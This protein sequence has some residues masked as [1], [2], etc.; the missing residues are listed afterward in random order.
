MLRSS[1]T[2]V[3]SLL[4]T[5]HTPII[6]DIQVKHLYTS[7][8]QH[9]CLSAHLWLDPGPENCGV[10]IVPLRLT[11]FFKRVCPPPKPGHTLCFVWVPTFGCTQDLKIAHRR[12]YSSFETHTLLQESLPSAEAW[13]YIVL[14][15]QT[16][17]RL[18]CICHQSYIGPEFD[19]DLDH[20]YP[21]RILAFSFFDFSVSVRRDNFWGWDNIS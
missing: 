13:T 11:P 10:N 18:W 6:Y 19:S 15:V 8:S 16:A 12:E 2:C 9:V 14:P 21:H 4:P 5:H 7:R 3:A 1:K 20:P 17:F